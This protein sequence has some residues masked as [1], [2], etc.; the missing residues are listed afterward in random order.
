MVI[1]DFYDLSS[2]INFISRND[3]N[4]Y[5]SQ[6]IKDILNHARLFLRANRWAASSVIM[7]SKNVGDVVITFVE[8]GL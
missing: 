2:S 3:T 4:I 6:Y 8:V 7:G 5:Y 1:P